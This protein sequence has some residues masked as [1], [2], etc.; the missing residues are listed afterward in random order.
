MA[1]NSTSL[2]SAL[3]RSNTMSDVQMLI[4]AMLS[5]QTQLSEIQENQRKIMKTLRDMRIE[6]RSRLRISANTAGVICCCASLR[7]CSG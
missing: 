4:D 7:A 1:V 6:Q 2:L 5:I 3:T